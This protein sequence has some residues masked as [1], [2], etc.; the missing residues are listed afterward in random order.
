MPELNA[1][2]PVPVLM[3]N[4]AD[5]A[6]EIRKQIV[7]QFAKYFVGAVFA[8]LIFVLA[9]VW[10]YIKTFYLPWI[11]VVP[12]GAVIAMDSPSGC[13]GILGGWEPFKAGEGRFV[14]GVGKSSEKYASQHDYQDK[15]G[16]DEKHILTV[17]ELPKSTVELAWAQS[18]DG[19]SST[20]NQFVG[21][22][23]RP[24]TGHFKEKFD[25]PGKGEAF[26]AM[27]PY[28]ALYLCKKR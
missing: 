3:A 20:F 18:V 10:F 15:H 7:S 8:V 16:G 4:P 5:V 24:G 28:I 13:E 9:A 27:P 26:E 11:G 19:S 6:A 12:A 17:D 23:S 2:Q 21:G 22:G 1:G 25:L 14:I